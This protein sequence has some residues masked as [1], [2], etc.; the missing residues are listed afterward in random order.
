MQ[1]IV[2]AGGA[3]TRLRSRVADRPKPMAPRAGRPFLEHLLDYWTRQGVSSFVLSLGHLA[4]AVVN[5]FG[6]SYRG[7]GLVHSV[8][9]APLG[10]GG[11]ALLAASRLT[12]A[13]P[14]LLLNGDTLFAVELPALKRA[15]EGGQAKVTRALVRQSG[16]LIGGGVYLLE[17]AGALRA[18]GRKAGDAFSLESELLPILSSHGELHDVEFQAPFIDIGTPAEYDRFLAQT[19]H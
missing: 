15:H 13:S 17:D 11:G 5:H 7:A 2:L 16:R 8:E 18:S 10:T 4:P 3:G 19:V 9:N 14:F 12:E 1:A 6:E